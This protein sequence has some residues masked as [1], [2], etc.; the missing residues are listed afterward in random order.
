MKVLQ[1]LLDDLDD[2]EGYGEGN[3]DYENTM[4]ALGVAIDLMKQDL[5]EDCVS[6]KAVIEA[7]HRQM[8]KFV[9]KAIDEQSE[10]TDDKVDLLLAVNKGI[11]G[12]VRSLPPVTPRQKCGKWLAQQEANGDDY[13]KAYDINGVMA[14]ATKYKCDKCSFIQICIEDHGQYNYCPNCGCRIEGKK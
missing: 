9:D 5:C 14:Y 8:F 11:I 3:K 13:F 12:A 1:V 10:E 6:R 4:V 2:D 7:I